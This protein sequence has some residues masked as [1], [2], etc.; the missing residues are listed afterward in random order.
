MFPDLS[1]IQPK[2]ESED[3]PTCEEQPFCDRFRQFMDHPELRMKSNAYYSIPYDTVK[4][5]ATNG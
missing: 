2:A 1:D 5:D 4:V 3:R